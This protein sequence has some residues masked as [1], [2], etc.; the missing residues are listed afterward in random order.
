MFPTVAEKIQNSFWYLRLRLSQKIAKQRLSGITALQKTLSL[1]VEE[2][3]KLFLLRWWRSGFVC[4]ASTVERRRLN[5]FLSSDRVALSATNQ[6][7]RNG[8]QN[9]EN[10][11]SNGNLHPNTHVLDG[12][13]GRGKRAEGLGAER[14]RVEREVSRG[15]TNGT[16]EQR[17]YNLTFYL[18]CFL[19]KETAKKK[20]SDKSRTTCHHRY[21]FWILFFLRFHEKV[22]KEKAKRL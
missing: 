12:R 15:R 13:R 1:Q 14:H 6:P 9:K 22:S 2:D 20:E 21:S 16:K 10:S 17:S 18:S 7:N 8:K 3:K 5:H 19:F 11:L 4:S